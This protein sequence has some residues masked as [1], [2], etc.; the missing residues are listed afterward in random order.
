[1]THVASSCERVT[2]QSAGWSAGLKI[3]RGE[4]ELLK[5]DEIPERSLGNR[6]GADGGTSTALMLLAQ[7]IEGPEAGISEA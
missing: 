1:V 7:S 4:V 6:R 3:G 2:G 5:F